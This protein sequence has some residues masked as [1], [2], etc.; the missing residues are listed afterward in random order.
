MDETNVQSY[1]ERE[2][3]DYNRDFYERDD[4]YPPLRYRHNYVLEMVGQL[5]WADNI[6]ILDAGCGPGETVIDLMQRNWSLWG[7]DI[8]D[9]MIEIAR[10]KL[11]KVKGKTNPVHFSVGDI[12]NLD[13]EPD[14][15]DLII[16][17]GVIEYL[18]DDEKWSRELDR[19]LKPG[20]ILIINITNRYAVRKWTAPLI[21]RLKRNKQLFA[22]MDYAKRN[23]IK[24]GK[25]NAFPFIPRMH[26]P[27]Q[28]DRFLASKGFIKITHRYF[29]FSILPAPFDTLMGF[30]SVPVR[31]YMER[32]S[33]WPMVL[34]GTGYI[35]CAR[36][37]G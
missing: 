21:D 2:A 37:Q 15:F 10:G 17:S 31:Q 9:A 29:D 5:K 27:G 3:G 20:G 19:V 28:F 14:Q 24:K 33:T 8:A 4:P 30:V 18:S 12:E 35:V 25:L 32:F 34:N 1:Y 16:C 22:F 36:K 23:I 6:K 11:A 13:F 26:G 7:I